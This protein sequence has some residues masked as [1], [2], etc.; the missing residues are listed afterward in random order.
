MTSAFCILGND[1]IEI[2]EGRFFD[3]VAR[4]LDNHV[5][6]DFRTNE[7]PVRGSRVAMSRHR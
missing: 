1:F 4:A 6:V 5:S 7:S 2:R 3:W